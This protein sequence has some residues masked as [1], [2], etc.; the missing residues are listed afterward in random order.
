MVDASVSHVVINC[1]SLQHIL[2]SPPEMI[3]TCR[4]KNLILDCPQLEELDLTPM[5]L[6]TSLNLRSPKITF[7]DFRN[8]GVLSDLNLDMDGLK[9]LN[10]LQTCMELQ[11][12]TLVCN[13]FK[14]FKF[15]RTGDIGPLQT[16]SLE[17]TNLETLETSNCGLVESLDVRCPSLKEWKTIKGFSRKTIVANID[18]P[19]LNS[20]LMV[21]CGASH[22]FWT[23]QL[24]HDLLSKIID[25]DS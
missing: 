1:K 5:H 19:S 2:L 12:L 24:P 3:S 13:Q 16:F 8:N 17:S 25:E 4:I 10:G 6:L 9:E 15:L 20:L 23:S 14:H 18:C 7:L 22:Q 11:N 21:N